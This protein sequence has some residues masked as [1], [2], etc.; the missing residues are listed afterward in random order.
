MSDSLKTN[1]IHPPKPRLSL[2]IGITGHRPDRLQKDSMQQLIARIEDV[3]NTINLEFQKIAKSADIG[4]AYDL[5]EP[6]ALRL[7]SPLAEGADRIAVECALKLGYEL[8]CPLPFSQSEY[9]NDFDHISKNRFKDLLSHATRKIELDGNRSKHRQAYLQVGHFVLRHA[10]ILLVVCDDKEDDVGVG[11][12]RMMVDAKTKNIPVIR[13]NANAPHIIQYYDSTG[14][15][16]PFGNTEVAKL[17]SQIL[18]PPDWLVSAM[19]K[20]SKTNQINSGKSTYFSYQRHKKINFDFLGWFYHVFF[21]FFGKNFSLKFKP[22]RYWDDALHYQWEKAISKSAKFFSKMTPD[23][24]KELNQRVRDHFLWADSLA[25]YYANQYRA[26]F[27]L[28]FG[29]SFV[30]VLLATLALSS[31][32]PL[33]PEKLAIAE[34][35]T[36]MIVLGLNIIGWR[37]YVHQ[38]WL[39]FRLL[40]ERL[41]QQ[42]ILMP[43][44]GVSELELPYYEVASEKKAANKHGKKKLS[45]PSYAWVDWLV[46]AI[47]RADGIPNHNL[48]ETFLQAYKKYLIALVKDQAAYHE[49]ASERHHR[50]AHFF[51]GS[52]Y[53][54]LCIVL[55]ACVIHSCP[56][57]QRQL[58]PNFTIG[59]GIAAA[60]LPALGAAIAGLL[61]QGEFKRIAQRSEGMSE[62]LDQIC[63]NLV[64]KETI[65]SEELVKTAHKAIA[66]M[67]EELSDW[68]V[69]FRIKV[70]EIHA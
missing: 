61:T 47:N 42:I 21:T 28:S 20:R 29:L 8:Q 4:K 24:G 70:L 34:F 30:A 65:S 50:I 66:L 12:A 38:R 23:I 60:V 45:L 25:T 27:G 59:A 67:S 31:S 5:N 13:V 57:L 19:N 40:A 43:L 55:F 63:D 14:K 16:L 22:P 15:Y 11:A 6:P 17:L 9:E 36:I 2:H 10:D 41:R 46:R 64:K 1:N 51:H 37:F 69:L 26:I 48:D 32:L 58:D 33:D 62:Q 56:Y 35:A 52:T 54:L 49:T 44:G 39:D 7:I 53:V 18:L 68:R 3:L